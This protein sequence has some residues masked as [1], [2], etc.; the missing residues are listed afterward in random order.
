MSITTNKSFVDLYFKLVET[1]GLQRK[2]LEFL[3]EGYEQLPNP[4]NPEIS[5]SDKY[6]VLDKVHSDFW[7]FVKEIALVPRQ[8]LGFARFSIN[9]TNLASLI[10][11]CDGI[12]VFASQPRQLYGTMTRVVFS[13]WKLLSSDDNVCVI[14]ERLED[15]KFFKE[16]IKL[17]N[18]LLPEYIRLDDSVI[19]S[20][21]WSRNSRGSIAFIEY[22]KGLIVINDLEH[23][24]SISRY[25]K[26]IRDEGKFRD[27]SIQVTANST[28][29]RLDSNGRFVADKIIAGS[30]KWN[31][32]HFRSKYLRDK[33][34]TE[35]VYVIYPYTELVDNP[36]EWLKLQSLYM[37][38]NPVAISKELLL[39]R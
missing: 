24:S 2:G 3:V 1:D 5:D 4:F 32:E 9:K 14:S 27:G 30:K 13:L 23:M 33:I 18:N 10:C 22:F 17:M 19:E 35:F 15:C 21:V 39:E 28:V 37:N 36:E 6:A 11:M 26:K 12:N 20:R 7:Y 34:K 38:N 25:I 29:G 8:G 16:K 31:D